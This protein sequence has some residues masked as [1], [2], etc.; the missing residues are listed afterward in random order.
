MI[1]ERNAKIFS[2]ITGG[3]CI[4]LLLVSILVLRDNV[5]ELSDFPIFIVMI[6]IEAV[7]DKFKIYTGRVWIS[8][9]SIIELASFLLLGIVAAALAQ[10][11]FIIITDYFVY[12]KPLR[13]VSVNIGMTI[14]K[15]YF[16]ALVYSFVMNIIG[17]P[18]TNFFS[19]NMLLPAAAFIFT[20]FIINYLFIIVYFLIMNGRMLRKVIFE[21]ILWEIIS[22]LVSIP[23]ALEF[24]DIYRFSSENN[25]WFSILFILPVIFSCFIFSLVRKIMFANTQLKA[26]SKVALTINSY[27]DIEKTYNSLLDAISSLVNFDGCYIFDIDEKRENMIPA[28]YR[29]EDSTDSNKVYSFNILKSTLGRVAGNTRAVIVN[30]LSKEASAHEDCEYCRLYKSCILVPMRRLNKCIGCI[31]IFSEEERAYNDEIL[32]FLMILSDQAS[33]AIENAKLYKM[34]EEES[35]TDSLTYLYNQKYF[36]NY[37]DRKIKESADNSSKISLILFDIDFFKRINDTYGHIVGDYVLKEVARLIKSSVRKNDIVARYGGEEFTAIL[38]EL[39]SDGAYVIAER[40]REKIENHVFLIDGFE[41][42]ITVS[43]GIAEYPRIASNAIEL[44]SYADRAMY[45]GA[46]F[47]GR[48]KIKVYDEKLA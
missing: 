28:A 30:D 23:I 16:G 38:P 24:A 5:M 39:D 9:V 29:I 46:K 1:N 22:V 32:E 35:I 21:S 41:I 34:T 27:L 7:V 10:L 14:G 2:Y 13:T 36:Y 25:L 20:A 19:V 26:V 18:N 17:R 44:V 12:K 40:I 45:V 37:M 43:G 31:G 15:M 4:S 33:I 48:N 42:R 6:I 3:V 47:K 8:F 11:F